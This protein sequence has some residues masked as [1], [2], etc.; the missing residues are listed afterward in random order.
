[1]ILNNPRDSIPYEKEKHLLDNR[2]LILFFKR[3]LIYPSIRPFNKWKVQHQQSKEE[4][5]E[6]ENA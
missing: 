2:E 3:L 1:M 6:P 4:E 5:K